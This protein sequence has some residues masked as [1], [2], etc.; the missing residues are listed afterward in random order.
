M[1]KLDTPGLDIR[2]RY[3]HEYS[4]ENILSA[5]NE[6]DREIFLRHKIEVDDQ[7]CDGIFKSDVCCYTS[8]VEKLSEPV[9]MI[10]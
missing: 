4:D 9:R 7:F 5:Y 2:D 1:T 3:F 6:E 10:L 8:D